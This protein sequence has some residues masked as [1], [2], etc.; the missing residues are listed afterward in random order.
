MCAGACVFVFRYYGYKR[1]IGAMIPDSGTEDFA[2][3]S[4][5]DVARMLESM[6]RAATPSPHLPLPPSRRVAGAVHDPVLP[7]RGGTTTTS[8][9]GD[10]ESGAWVLRGC[11]VG[12]V[13]VAGMQSVGVRVAMRPTRLYSLFALHPAPVPCPLFLAR[14]GVDHVIS[15]DLQPP[16]FGE[17]EV[18]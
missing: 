16:G 10:A 12:G 8:R 9:C 17:I 18:R 13:G 7:V 15:V 11:G 3:M 2:S 6:V 4:A 5:A 14:Q 1:D